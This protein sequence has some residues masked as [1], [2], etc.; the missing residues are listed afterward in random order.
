VVQ[1]VVRDVVLADVIPDL[2]SIP[3]GERADLDQLVL[4]VP[5]RDAEVGTARGLAPHEARHPHIHA[6]ERATHRLDFADAAAEVGIPVPELRAGLAGLLLRRKCGGAVLEAE[7]GGPPHAPIPE[8]RR[9][10]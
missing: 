6:L 1:L 9:A 2:R 8:R 7:G 10:G 4:P 5:A 3:S